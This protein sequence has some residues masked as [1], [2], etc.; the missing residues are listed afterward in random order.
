ML[1]RPR[2]TF[3]AMSEPDAWFW[4]AVLLGVGYMVYLSGIGA[5]MFELTGAV[6]ARQVGNSSSARDPVLQIVLS[7]MPPI[8]GFVTIIQAPLTAALSW[9]VRCLVFSGLAAA[10]R[11][12][13]APAG[14]VAAMVGW[15][16]VPLL[17][18]YCLIGIAV[19]V[20]PQVGSFFLGVQPDSDRLDAGAVGRLSWERQTMLMLSPFVIWN[21]LLCH[22]GVEETFKLPRWKAGIVVLLPTLI[23]FGFQIGMIA[24]SS[25]FLKLLS[26]AG[27][28]AEPA[29]PIP[30]P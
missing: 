13:R 17:F 19:L 16:W 18:Q 11:G 23:Q 10:L 5:R 20:S 6:L 21:L 1:I 30:R 28:S 15:A 2:A 14:R 3:A 22:I 29:S 8:E 27:G 26:G 4:P 9:V 7:V 24:L 25:S 12:A